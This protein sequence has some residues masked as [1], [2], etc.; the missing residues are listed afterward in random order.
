MAAR[1]NK[2]FFSVVF[3]FVWTDN[4]LCVFLYFFFESILWVVF[5]FRFW[6]CITSKR[7]MIAWCVRWNRTKKITR[8]YT[9][10]K[11]QQTFTKEKQQKRQKQRQQ[12]Q[13]IQKYTEQQQNIETA[14]IVN[15]P[16]IKFWRGWWESTNEE[17]AVRA[18]EMY[19][20]SSA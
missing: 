5:S 8:C 1:L 7:R 15:S 19:A 6:I 2:I 4:C 3:F 18:Q 16:V 10:L 12:Q 13:R 14:N 11:K 9:I 20:Y 17:R